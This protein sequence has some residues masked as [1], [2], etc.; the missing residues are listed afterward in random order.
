MPFDFVRAGHLRIGVDKTGVFQLKVFFSNDL[1]HK[2]AKF[3][4]PYLVEK[5]TET[6][7]VTPP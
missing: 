7:I 4:G 1:M 3:F 2:V 6:L 5:L